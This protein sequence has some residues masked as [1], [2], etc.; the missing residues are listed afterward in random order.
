LGVI[1]L[2]AIPP[3]VTLAPIVELFSWLGLTGLVPSVWI[4][5][6]GFTMP[7]GIFILVAFFDELPSEMLEAAHVDGAN[8]VQVFL[9]VALPL[10]KPGLISVLVLHFLFSW[11]DLLIPLLLLRPDS[12]PI[13]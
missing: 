1:S 10:A 3:A 5:Q 9:R 6:S 13:T 12:A 2:L 8:P 7:L 11:N 4:F